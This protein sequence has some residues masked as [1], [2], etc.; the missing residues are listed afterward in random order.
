MMKY[1][2]LKN[3]LKPP[4]VEPKPLLVGCVVAVDPNKGL[5]TVVDVLQNIDVV[6]C[7]VVVC[8]NIDVVGLDCD[9]NRLP[10]FKL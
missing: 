2:L 9:P 7:V 8:P 4:V 6:G 5:L 10:L 1:F 3:S